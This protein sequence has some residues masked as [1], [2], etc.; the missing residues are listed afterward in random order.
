MTF[1]TLLVE[2][3]EVAIDTMIIY[4]ALHHETKE[5]II[6]NSSP[7]NLIIDQNINLIII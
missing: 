3:I 4:N 2:W 7:T 1:F 5:K 6:I